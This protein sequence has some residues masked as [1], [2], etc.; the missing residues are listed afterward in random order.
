[1][2]TVDERRQFER[3]PTSIRVEMTHPA[4]GTIIGFARDI[5][6]GGASV[7]IEN[8]QV[9]PVGTIVEVRFKKMV[10]PINA[11]PV[12]MQIVHHHRNTAGLMFIPDNL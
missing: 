9:P 12:K 4:F 3:K 8:Y 11:E 5:S 7:L 10:G 1:M 6:D 2:I